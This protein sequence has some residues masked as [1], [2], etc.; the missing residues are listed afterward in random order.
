MLLPHPTSSPAR[1]AATL[2]T[3]VLVFSFAIAQPAAHAQSEST[4]IQRTANGSTSSSG[5]VLWVRENPLDQKPAQG[6]AADPDAVARQLAAQLVRSST[7]SDGLE[8]DSTQML[9][10]EAQQALTL[11]DAIRIALRENYDLQSAELDVQTARAQVREARGSIYPRVDVSGSYTRN[12]VQ[13][14]PFAGSDLGAILGGGSQAD[15]VAFNEQARQD[16]DPTTEPITLEEFRQR[17]LEA[18]QEAG[19]SFGSSGNPFGIDNEFLGSVQVTQALYDKSAFSALKGAQ[20]FQDVSRRSLDRQVQTVANDVYEAYY[21]ALLAQE[22]VRVIQQRTD[23][24]KQTLQEVSA[25]VR[26]GVSPKLERMSTEVELSN[27]RTELIQAENDANLALDQLKVTLGLT[28]NDEI[29]LDGVLETNSQDMFINI[30]TQQ[31]MTQAI[32]QRP[33]LQRAQ[34]AIDLREIERET[35]EAQYYPTLEAV[36]TFSYAGRVPDDREQVLTDPNDPFFYDT[37]QRDFFDDQ[38]WNPTI[39]AGLQMSWNVFN[40]FQTTARMEQQ[41][42]EISK[43]QLQRDQ[44]RQNI[45]LEVSSALRRL[46]TA[47]RR[48]QSQRQTVQNAET[49][50]QFTERRLEEGVSSPLQVREASDQLDR[51]RLNYLQ[52]VYDYLVARSDLETALG[53]PLTPATDDYQMTTRDAPSGNTSA[54]DASAEGSR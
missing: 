50:Y 10:R 36:A 31:A 47:R 32:D 14:N 6:P 1:F 24:T 23:R 11:Q 12:I 52:A 2:T 39:S 4:D 16:N 28:V 42:I 30:S 53:M 51:S 43:A 18:Q 35:I 15:W 8:D 29:Q 48:I 40:G 46:E 19:V 7:A 5:D 37:V 22:Q 27:L 45:E 54:R 21:G 26:R 3:L 38:Y 49:S 20:Q 9:I 44:L 17:Q 34:L 13:A 41:D 25:R 33:D